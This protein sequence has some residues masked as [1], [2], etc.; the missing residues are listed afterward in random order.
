MILIW[1]PTLVH[2]PFLTRGW[3]RVP[4]TGASTSALL[5]GWS[6]GMGPACQALPCPTAVQQQVFSSHR[7]S[8]S[9]CVLVLSL[10]V[11]VGEWGNCY[12]EDEALTWICWPILIFTWDNKMTNV[13]GQ[14]SDVKKKNYRGRSE[15]LDCQAMA[16]HRKT[17]ACYSKIPHIHSI[18]CRAPER[19]LL[20]GN[21][22]AP[23]L[24][25]SEFHED[26]TWV[27]Q[28]GEEIN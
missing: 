6:C 21:R 18:C 27:V 4:G 1:V 15:T 2:D 16:E 19:H 7:F 14:S 26:N 13:F 24:C 3:G 22:A 23:G 5:P 9:L 25:C 10:M 17:M 8:P 12:I 11:T 28:L 20:Q